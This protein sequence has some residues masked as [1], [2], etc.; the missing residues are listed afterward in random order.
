MTTIYQQELKYDRLYTAY[1]SALLS[2]PLLLVRILVSLLQFPQFMRT[3]F[4][5]LTILPC[6][7]MA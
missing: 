5:V 6:L 3:M 2:A 7:Y 1:Q 4:T